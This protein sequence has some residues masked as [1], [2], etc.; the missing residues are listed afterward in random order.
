MDMREMIGKNNH[1]FFCYFS[2]ENAVFTRDLRDK[3]NLRQ[4]GFAH[5]QML[6]FI[7]KE[8]QRK[9]FRNKKI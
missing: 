8:K 4:P 3:N 7:H 1:F 2:F 9:R 5:I 6:L